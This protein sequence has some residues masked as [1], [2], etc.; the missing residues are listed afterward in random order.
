MQAVVQ[1]AVPAGH[2][3]VHDAGNV[4]DHD[5][6]VEDHSRHDGLG[7]PLE[8]LPHA[9]LTHDQPG[10][11][12][13]RGQQQQ[14]RHEVR[15]HHVL[16]HVGRVEGLL[17]QVV[18]GPVRRHPQDDQ[19][20]DEAPHLPPADRWLPRPDDAGADDLDRVDVAGRQRRHQQPHFEVGLEAPDVGRHDADHGGP[21]PIRP[22]CARRA[23]VWGQ[24]LR[25]SPHPASDP[26][27]PVARPRAGRRPKVDYD[28]NSPSNR[29]LR[30]RNIR[31]WRSTG[32][33]PARRRTPPP[34]G[35][36]RPRTSARTA[37][38]PSG[39]A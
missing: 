25:R 11:P 13:R 24:R 7:Q 14:R 20:G 36:H 21:P 10:Q 38:S 35:A 34:P 17:G 29:R 8:D 27:G 5:E 33:W 16:E 2:R 30:V 23:G 19:A 26:A 3:A 22:S 9:A 1:P 32:T 12:R 39:G 28:Q 4:R 37:W 18:H 15:Q 6:G 31:P